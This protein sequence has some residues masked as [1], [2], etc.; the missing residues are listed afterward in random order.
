MTAI[1]KDGKARLLLALMVLLGLGLLVI[2]FLLTP[3]AF[4]DLV[5]RD[6]VFS[7]DL[8]GQS[9]QVTDDASGH[10]LTATVQKVG[11]DFLA[12]VGR[13]DSGETRS[14]AVSVAGYQPAP[15]TLK[16]L[17][18]QRVRGAV[19]LVPTFGRLELSVV[20]A[21]QTDEPVSALLK[22]GGAA[23][24]PQPLSVVALNLPAGNHRFS[25]QAG[26]FCPEER[27]VQVEERKLTRIK[28]ALSPDLTGDEVAR[29]VLD[30][31]PNPEDLDAHF[32]KL[33]TSGYPN[34]AHVFFHHMEGT[35]GGAVFARLDVDY[36]HGDG[37]ETV[38]VYDKAAGEY[39]YYVHRYAG[40]GTLGTSSARVTVFTRGCQKRQLL[41]P[42][43]CGEDIW[44]VAHVRIAQG[45]VDL[46]D[47]QK[48]ENDARLKTPFKAL[49]DAHGGNNP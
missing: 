33:G 25:A 18:L 46:L 27:E 4:M 40:E 19:N 49:S 34:P 48:C 13:I 39:E 23:I 32:R 5:F 47:E 17:P 16:A 21:T 43:D 15:V 22:K 31:G 37:Y 35:F 10:T 12:R 2:P 14:F 42:T 9:V 7:S 44:N 30:W 6:T 11:G 8:S 38:T 36:R 45:R 3:P 24:S 1:R 29:F 28:L 26:G 20:N 41:V